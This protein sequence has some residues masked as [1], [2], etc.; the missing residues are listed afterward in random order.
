MLDTPYREQNTR[1]AAGGAKQG[2]GRRSQDKEAGRD[3]YEDTTCHPQEYT[4]FLLQTVPLLRS[5]PSSLLPKAQSFS[6]KHFCT[7]LLLFQRALFKST[8]VFKFLEAD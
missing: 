1:V 6:L 2:R 5:L 7:S 4:S 3:G 8:R